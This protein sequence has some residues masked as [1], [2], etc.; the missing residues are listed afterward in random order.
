MRD[1]ADIRDN[2]VLKTL[3][4]ELVG[5]C[6]YGEEIDVINPPTISAELNTVFV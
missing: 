2:I 5:P 1:G 3:H 6:A 4:E